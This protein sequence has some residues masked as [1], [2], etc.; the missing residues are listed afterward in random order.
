MLAA[1]AMPAGEEGRPE[2]VGGFGSCTGPAL[3]IFADAV[4]ICAMGSTPAPPLRHRVQRTEQPNCSGWGELNFVTFFIF[5]GYGWGPSRVCVTALPSAGPQ[6]V[7]HGADYVPDILV[8]LR[9]RAC[10][11]V[12]S[13][14]ICC[15]ESKFVIFGANS[16]TSHFDSSKRLARSG[17]SPCFKRE[18]PSFSQ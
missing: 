13:T 5:R 15:P 9:S 8:A 18:T 7:V 10:L 2:I 11:S 16:C 1:P 3:R 6:D 14:P 17:T 12:V 4:V